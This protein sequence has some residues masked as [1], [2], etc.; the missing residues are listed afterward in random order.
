MLPYVYLSRHVCVPAAVMTNINIGAGVVPTILIAAWG[1][2]ET[3]SYHGTHSAKASV[4]VFG[5]QEGSYVDPLLD[6]KSNPDVSF[7]DVTTVSAVE[8]SSMHAHAR[9]VETG[10]VCPVGSPLTRRE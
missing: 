10:S 1:D 5:E 8:A 2:S 4:A 3:V 6:L 9:A 7:F